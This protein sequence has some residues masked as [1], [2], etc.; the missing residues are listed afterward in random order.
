[1]LKQLFNKKTGFVY[2]LSY[3]MA[4]M[5]G[6]A[7]TARA[8]ELVIT[9]NGSGS[10][11]EVNTQVEQQTSV[12]QT[13]EANVSNE[14][15]LDSNTGGNEASSNTGG[16]VSI[17]TGDVSQNV[18]VET[19]V[20]SSQVDAGC[21]PGETEVKISGNGADST[22][23]VNLGS[24]NTTNIT[25][26][27]SANVRN[28]L[29][30][31][32]NTGENTA[33][34]NTGG[35]FSIDTGDIKVAGGLTNGPINVSSINASS[36]TG[37]VSVDVSGNGAGSTNSVN[38]NFDNQTN[39]STNFFANLLNFVNWD[40]N[41]GRNSANGNT[42]GNVS[43][44]TGDILFDFFIKN[45]P[46]NSG[47]IDIDCCPFDPGEPPG[48]G[49]P[50]G[51]EQPPEG[52]EPPDEDVPGDEDG[53]DDGEDGGQP[54]SEAGPPSGGGGGEVLGLGDTGGLSNP[55]IFWAG[56]ALLLLGTRTAASS[57]ADEK[58]YKKR[59]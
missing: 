45:G 59:R 57:F 11:N 6:A 48:N 27:Q 28:N 3:L 16:D 29:Q 35:N 9:D 34:N 25:T 54:L 31:S 32:A 52:E 24:T 41:T 51:E 20:N 53:G 2:I 1:M 39:A 49:G 17:D 4:F 56:L 47:I 22:N 13:N 7:P 36:G 12:E 18:E 14:A 21:C 15:N 50:P 40:L 44:T 23:T 26:N 55:L 38:A 43:I 46:I 8:L 37:G 5:V 58:N 42:G 19:A 30:G 10:A 33:N